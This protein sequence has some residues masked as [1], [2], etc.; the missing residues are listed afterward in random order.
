VFLIRTS[1]LPYSAHRRYKIVPLG[2]FSRIEELP[3]SRNSYDLYYST[4]FTQV[5]QT[6][7]FNHGLVAL[8]DCLR[9]L[10]EHGRESGRDWGKGN[11]EYVPCLVY[12]LMFAEYAKTRFHPTLSDCQDSLRH[13]HSY[14]ER[15]H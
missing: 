3:P 12:L 9:Q 11:I 2:S 10:V 6:R 4:E 1:S 5:L 13:N 8:L 7:K 15:C 14:P